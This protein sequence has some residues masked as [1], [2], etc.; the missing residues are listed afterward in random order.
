MHDLAALF[1]EAASQGYIVMVPPAQ[2]LALAAPS[3]HD[4][5]E[6]VAVAILR[7]RLELTRA[8]A[9]ALLALARRGHA[10]KQEL[11]TAIAGGAPVTGPKVIEVI[12]SRLRAKL[13]RE[14]EIKTIWGV[15]Y[16]LTETARDSVRALLG[17]SGEKAFDAAPPPDPISS[18]R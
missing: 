17:S 14:I 13:P 5:A 2:Q 3:T 18:A 11:H 8:E 7:L 1:R 9:R 16:A 10:S 6:A 4:N 12:I 15:G